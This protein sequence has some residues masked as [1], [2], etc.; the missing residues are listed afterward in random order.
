MSPSK[1]SMHSF[2]LAASCTFFQRKSRL[3]STLRLLQNVA[4]RDI[5]AIGIGLQRG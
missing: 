2:P 1:R 5:L 4:I 3:S